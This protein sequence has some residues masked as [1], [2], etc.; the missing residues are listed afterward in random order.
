LEETTADRGSLPSKPK[1]SIKDLPHKVFAFFL[2]TIGL[3]TAVAIWGRNYSYYLMPLQERPAFSRYDTLR[4]DGFESHGYG[5]IGTAMIFIGVAI[6]SS[7]K[8][9]KRLANLGKISDFLNFHIFLCLVGPILVLYHTTFLFGGIAG[10]G[11]WCMTAVVVSGFIGRYFYKFIPKNLQGDELS[12][13]DLET[14]RAELLGSLVSRYKLDDNTVTLIDEIG[15]VKFDESK[16]G[17]LSL[18]W[19]LARMDLSHWQNSRRL[20]TVLHRRSVPKSYV[21]EITRIANR[22]IVLRQRMLVLEKIRQ[23]FHYWHVIHLPFSYVMLVILI[24]HVGVAVAFG[25]TWIF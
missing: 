25:Y 1:T 4:P 21:R 12:S 14:E 6:Y 15:I 2:I 19:Y 5:V 11:F 22:R 16:A 13:R 18:F 9:L 17:L 24:I 8:R 20:R 3:I 7:R 23:I 10:A